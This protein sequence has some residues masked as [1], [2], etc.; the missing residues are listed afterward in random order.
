MQVKYERKNGVYDKQ[1]SILN[2]FYNATY[3]K[4]AAENMNRAAAF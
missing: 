1:M 4:Q 3:Y 2:E